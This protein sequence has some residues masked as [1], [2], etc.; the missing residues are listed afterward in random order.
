MLLANVV[1]NVSVYSVVE[2]FTSLLIIESIVEASL[3]LLVDSSIG[4]IVDF[5]FSLFN[6]S[7]V[8]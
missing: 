3:G 7:P 5:S 8:I 6:N 2:A 4:S 1:I